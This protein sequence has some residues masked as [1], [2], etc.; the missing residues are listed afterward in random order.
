MPNRVIRGEINSSDSLSQV[1]IEADL[2]FR[3]LLVAV[4]DFGR[5]DARPAFL[6]AALFP[7]REAVTP[8]KV[9]RWI[10]ELAGEGCVQLYEVDGRPYLCLP[11]WETHRGKARRAACSK[12]PDPPKTPTNQELPGDPRISGNF[13]DF[14]SGG[15]GGVGDGSGVGEGESLRDPAPPGAPVSEPP[16]RG[17]TLAPVQLTDAETEALRAWALDKGHPS[18]PEALAHAWET[19]RL[20]SHSN[21]KKK[22]NWYATTQGAIRKGWALEGFHSG[23]DPPPGPQSFAAQDAATNE[24]E[25]RKYLEDAAGRHEPVNPGIAGDSRKVL[26]DGL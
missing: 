18:T 16:K 13:Q 24:N 7:T 3:A 21:A 10:Q 6:K 22:P 8:R 1:S 15:G 2:T 23:T 26:P 4:D 20:W 17:P 5:M 12:H 25:V 14:L 19:V 9:V 11:S